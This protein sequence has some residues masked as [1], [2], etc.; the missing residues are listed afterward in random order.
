MRQSR[1]SRPKSR[2][3]TTGFLNCMHDW[4]GNNHK[5]FGGD[6]INKQVMAGCFD[7][8]KLN[9]HKGDWNCE[10]CCAEVQIRIPK[11]EFH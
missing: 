10:H 5:R 7:I 2:H 11:F 9:R 4:L 1:A 6:C 8:R 3:I